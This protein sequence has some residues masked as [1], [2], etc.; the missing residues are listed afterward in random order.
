MI[1]RDTPFRDQ[2]VP[3]YADMVL[4]AIRKQPNPDKITLS[5]LANSLK[6][7][8]LKDAYRKVQELP[9]KSPCRIDGDVIIEVYTQTEN[10]SAS[11]EAAVAGISNPLDAAQRLE[12]TSA[13]V[14][15]RDISATHNPA[16]R[17]R[18]L[19][20]PA[21]EIWRSFWAGRNA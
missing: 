18:F 3:P 2:P 6:E 19:K 21:I 12:R 4:K 14:R 5:G 7:M 11:T 16:P 20:P 10:A 15:S 9:R 13:D 8:G 17:G 1:E